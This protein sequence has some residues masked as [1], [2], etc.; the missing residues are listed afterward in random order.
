MWDYVFGDFVPFRGAKKDMFK[1]LCLDVVKQKSEQ[2]RKMNSEAK[3]AY[4]AESQRDL[5]KVS[6]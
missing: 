5:R 4:I 6:G 2:F 1:S 3:L